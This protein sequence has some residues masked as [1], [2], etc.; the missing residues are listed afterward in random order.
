MSLKAGGGSVL[1][2]NFRGALIYDP[3]KKHFGGAFFAA[4]SIPN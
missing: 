1:R 2:R 3:K 4:T